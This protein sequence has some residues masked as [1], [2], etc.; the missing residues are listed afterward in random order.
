MPT[1]SK[2]DKV[3]EAI[4]QLAQVEQRTAERFE[5]LVTAQ[6]RT[7]EQLGEL[8]RGQKG[9]VDQLKQVIS[10]LESLA[11]ARAHTEDRLDLLTSHMAELADAQKRTE[12]RVEDLIGA[13]TRTEAMLAEL[14]EAQKRT[15]QRLE[16]LAIRVDELAEAQKRTEA[17]L[18]ELAEAQK[19]TE[20]RLEELAEAQAKTEARLDD[21]NKQLGGLAMSFGYFLENES[22]KYLPSLLARDYGIS[23]QGELIRSYIRDNQDKYL[24]VNILGEGVRNGERF[25]IV[26]ESKS[27]LS[28]NSIEKF[29]YNK[30][31][32]LDPP[33]GMKLFP[34]LVCHMIS[35][36]EV[37]QYAKDK[38]IA[39]YYSYQFK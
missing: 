7:V 37:A 1:S 28:V 5:E 8:A 10:Q 30:L 4:L 3:V 21:T 26:G 34:I 17:K 6:D 20:K 39:L 29:I 9:T 35:S 33:A 25:L 31:N 32:R 19:E 11:T 38:G 12:F 24:E 16:A 13:Q 14:A 36:P 18:A 23:V 27:Q 22:Y 15:E 2:F